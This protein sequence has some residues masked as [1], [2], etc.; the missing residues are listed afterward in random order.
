VAGYSGTPLA[1][2]LGI[3]PSMMITAVGAPDDLREWLAPM[4]P[5]VSWVGG[6]KARLDLALMFV[7][8]R[9]EVE[10]RFFPLAGRVEPAGAIW[11]AWP[12][13]ASGIATDVT[14]NALR[15]IILPTGYVD[16]KVCA[17]SEVWSGLK[18]V[19]RKELRPPR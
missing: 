19:L 8:R 1:K 17:I 7:T 13:K 16:T 10:R 12:K 3:A 4:P 5:D 15:E 14:E 6:G 2:K 11:I 9:A 18:F